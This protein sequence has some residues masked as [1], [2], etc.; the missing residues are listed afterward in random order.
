MECFYCKNDTKKINNKGHFYCDGCYKTVIYLSKIK[1]FINYDTINYDTINQFVNNNKFTKT[2]KIKNVGE[3]TTK[4]CDNTL[5]IKITNFNVEKYNIINW[6]FD[7]IIDI[8]II[9][10]IKFIHG[11][12]VVLIK[13][14]DTFDAIYYVNNNI[15]KKRY[16]II[17]NLPNEITNLYLVYSG[18]AILDRCFPSGLNNLPISLKNII[19]SQPTKSLLAF[20]REIKYINFIQKSKIPFGCELSYVGG[21]CFQDYKPLYK[22]INEAGILNYMPYN[23]S[24]TYNLNK[25]VITNM[26]YLMQN[27]DNMVF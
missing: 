22:I 27:N 26:L 21:S 20:N 18:F 2:T 3:F 13:S 1:D 19:L 23:S 6:I 24:P 25:R 5:D 9:C 12:T 14:I 7:N 10:F 11:E 8:D 16:S 15:D 4:R 17:N